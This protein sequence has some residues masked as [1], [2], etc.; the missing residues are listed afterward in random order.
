[1]NTSKTFKLPP[2]D[3]W[4]LLSDREAQKIWLGTAAYFPFRKHQRVKIADDAGLWRE[5]FIRKTQYEESVVLEL[6][7]SIGG[8]PIANRSEC[9]IE[10]IDLGENS[11]K[12]LVSEVFAS[13]SAEDAK[14]AR[15]FWQAALGRL[16]GLTSNISTRRNSP[17]QAVVV[18]HGIGEQEPGVTLRSFVKGCFGPDELKWSKPDY[19]SPLFELRKITLA[20]SYNKSRPTTDFFELYWAHV[21]RDTTLA[22]ILAWFKLLLLRNPPSKF[23]R[24]WLTVWAIILILLAGGLLKILGPSHP[25][26]D[27]VLGSSL[28]VSIAAGIWQLVGKAVILDGL[29]DAVRYLT[30]RPSNISHRQSVRE[31][32]VELLHGLHMDGKYDRIVIVGHSL[33]SVIAYDIITHYW[34]R[35]H[36]LHLAPSTVYNKAIISVERNRSTK[37]SKTFRELQRNAWN[38][39][40][41][42]TQTWLVTDLVTLGSPLS[43]AS[44]LMADSESELAEAMAHREL[45]K[46]PP[47]TES[48]GRHERMSFDRSYTDREGKAHRTFKY[49]HHA[50]AFAVTR[51]TN[52]F[53]DDGLLKDPIGGPLAKIFGHWV[54]D[55]PLPDPLPKKYFLHTH[56]WTQFGEDQHINELLGALDLNVANELGD[57]AKLN[58]PLLYLPR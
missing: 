36:Q 18:I 23:F 30:P 46:C 24:V 52:L 41:K 27:F 4:Q 19:S 2:E 12:I 35:V 45:P 14:H 55:V 39:M 47:V 38:S 15:L 43:A 42:N 3:V 21:I 29:G 56:Y 49:F 51:W 58:N 7:P 5:G 8:A 25:V 48:D 17:R 50:A 16:S 28:L 44:Y 34:I 26:I 57:R 40:R 32:G 33:G 54:R 37:D 13:N 31:A 11:C 22:D 9:R 20:A 1:M 53:F 10:L 6:H